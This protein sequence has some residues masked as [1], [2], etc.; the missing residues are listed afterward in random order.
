MGVAI[1]ASAWRRGANVTLI[2]GPLGTPAPPGA[3][4]EEV[5]TVVEMCDAVAAAL[6]AAD[7]FIMAAAPADF[8]PARQALTKIKKANA[9]L[10]IPVERTPD[11]LLATAANRKAN[12]IVV[13]FA[14]ETDD[15]LANGRA[16]RTEKKLDLI[17]INDAREEGAGFDVDTNRVT[18]IDSRDSVEELPLLSKRQ[19]A[20]VILDRV[21]ELLGER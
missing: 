3:K 5:T 15:V 8:R 19:V 1:A 12:A 2:A 4:L 20:D 11:I 16:K 13:G 6:P 10:S 7:A 9:P 18:L 14:L 21:E 17:V